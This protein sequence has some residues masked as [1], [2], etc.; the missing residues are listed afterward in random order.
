VKVQPKGQAPAE[1]AAGLDTVSFTTP[2][3]AMLKRSAT[4]ALEAKRLANSFFKLLP[5]AQNPTQT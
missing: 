2:A 4:A 5:D 1:A 3:N